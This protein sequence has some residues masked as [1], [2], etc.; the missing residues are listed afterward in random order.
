M[1]T[2]LMEA[3]IY[4]CIKSSQSYTSHSHGVVC[5]LYLITAGE[6]K[7]GRGKEGWREGKRKEN[8]RKKER[9]R[10]K[11]EEEAGKR[12]KEEKGKKKKKDLAEVREMPSVLGLRLRKNL[13]AK[14]K[15]RGPEEPSAA[16][17]DS[18]Q[19]SRKL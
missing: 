19:G 5:Q 8:K 14:T 13:Y 3:T 18:R 11:K 15:K 7:G 16:L 17:A 1:L 12:R 10:E 9:G 6:R 4:T 2:N